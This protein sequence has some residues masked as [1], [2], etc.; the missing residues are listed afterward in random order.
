MS[1]QENGYQDPKNTATEFSEPEQLSPIDSEIQ[2]V[3]SRP[4]RRNFR[5]TSINTFPEDNQINGIVVGELFN[6]VD[7]VGDQKIFVNYPGNPYTTPLL[8]MT[9][10][11]LNQSDAGKQVVLSFD[12][13]NPLRPVIMGMLQNTQTPVEALAIDVTKELDSKQLQAK[14]DGD[15]VTLSAEKEIV[16]QCGKS[17]I[18]LTKAGKIIIR[19][20]YL[21]SRSTGVNKIKGGAVQIN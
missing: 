8:A 12:Q 21:L 15:Q 3:F 18:T 6:V 10:V 2:Q 5:S 1:N 20:E 9:T 11:K 16:L 13:G 7:E 14:L 17:S 19:G 4:V